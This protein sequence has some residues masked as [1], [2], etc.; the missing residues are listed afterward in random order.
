MTMTLQH[1]LRQG[2][3]RTKGVLII[4]TRFYWSLVC[5]FSLLEYRGGEGCTYTHIHALVHG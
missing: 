5:V 4:I 3:G 2:Q 1:D